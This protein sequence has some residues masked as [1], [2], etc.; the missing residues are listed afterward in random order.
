MD[1][2]KGYPIIRDSL[3]GDA[4]QHLTPGMGPTAYSVRS[5]PAFGSGSCPAL[6]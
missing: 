3:P 5:A 2:P 6:L 4:G 1:W